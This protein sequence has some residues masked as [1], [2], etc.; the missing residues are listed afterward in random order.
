MVGA[1]DPDYCFTGNE[2]DQDFD[3]LIELYNKRNETWAF[4]QMQQ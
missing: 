3:A 2:S 4:L 1:P